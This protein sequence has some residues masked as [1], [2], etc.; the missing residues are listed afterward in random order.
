MNRPPQ[1][2]ALVGTA[3]DP[4]PFDQIGRYRL[5]RPLGKGG[6]GIVYE[7]IHIDLQQTVALKLIRSGGR[8]DLDQVERFRREIQA[9]GAIL[10]PNV[11]RATDAGELDGTWYL[12]MELLEGLTLADL[13]KQ[14]GPLPISDA[15][16]L[17]RQAA[18]GLGAVAAKGRVHRDIKPQNLM[19]ARDPQYGD[20]NV[21][22]LKILDLGL[23][24][25]KDQESGDEDGI[26]A[27]YILG[28]FDY[29][30]P[31]QGR[32]S[33]EVDIRAD[34]YSLGC[35]FYNLLTGEPPYPS[36]RFKTHSEKLD[37]HELKPLPPL[38]DSVPEELQAIVKKMT[39]KQPTLRFQTPKEVAAALTPYARDHHIARFLTIKE[40][41]SATRVKTTPERAGT[42]D[43]PDTPTQARSTVAMVLPRKRRRLFVGIAAVTMIA[44]LG[45]WTA[46]AFVPWR[47]PVTD[48]RG[49]RK[50]GPENADP[51]DGKLKGDD[52]KVIPPPADAFTEIM[53]FDPG[54]ARDFTKSAPGVAHE[55]LDRA[56]VK[57]LWPKLDKTASACFNPFQKSVT[58]SCQNISMILFGHVTAPNYKFTVKLHQVTPINDVGVFI[59]YLPA[60]NEISGS[61]PRFQSIT[62]ENDTV[63]IARKFKAVRWTPCIEYK[64]NKEPAYRATIAHLWEMIEPPKREQTIELIVSSNILTQVKFNNQLISRL[65][66][67]NAAS[68]ATH[69]GFGILQRSANCTYREA[70]IEIYAK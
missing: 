14:R 49:D 37:A 39:A 5:V 66:T 31:E 30:S 53:D 18:L 8:H 6:M 67:R 11:V 62:I 56:P 3:P 7:A 69:G 41:S 21:V 34:I 33:H 50:D 19:L 32:R 59:G 16:E 28:T 65:T 25:L 63:G 55:L 15:C 44:F 20:A 52:T 70:T 35:T 46:W 51:K 29:L 38:P 12:V 24:L 27:R 43:H 60:A 23:A 58:V 64:P 47:E 61:T 45:I 40:G 22:N 2:P 42:T 57:L 48:R 17:I 54:N 10:H 13:I 4:L 9:V 36:P 1:S 26:T 68:A